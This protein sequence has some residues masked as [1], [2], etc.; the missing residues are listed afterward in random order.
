M[1]AYYIV[2]LTYEVNYYRNKQDIVIKIMMGKKMVRTACV[3]V[4][5]RRGPFYDPTD[6]LIQE[7][8]IEQMATS[9][10]TYTGTK[11]VAVA[12]VRYIDKIG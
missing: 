4:V 9:I 12:K 11:I 8:K 10:G 7:F 2:L 1:I 3:R 5:F 6:S